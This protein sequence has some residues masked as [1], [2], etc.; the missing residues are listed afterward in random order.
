M[1]YEKLKM[2]YSLLQEMYPNTNISCDV[3]L[4]TEGEVVEMNISADLN[5]WDETDGSNFPLSLVFWED[6]MTALKLAEG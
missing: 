6:K 5:G 2:L 4:G 3:G 1:R